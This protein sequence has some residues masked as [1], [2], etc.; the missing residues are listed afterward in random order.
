[1]LDPEKADVQATALLALVKLGRPSVDQTVK[2]LKGQ[3]ENLASFAARRVKEITNAK[4]PPKDKPHV[5]TAALILGTIGRP[6]AVQ[7]MI[8]A[9]KSTDDDINKA[10][11]ARELTKLPAT[12]A[13]KQAFKDAFADI[14]IDTVIPPGANA[15]QMLAEAAGQFYDPEFI[16]WLLDRAAGTKGGGEDLKSLQG[17]ITVTALKLA[18]PDQLGQVKAAVDKYGTQIE[19]DLYAHTQTVLKGCGDRVSCYLTAIEK[20]ENQEQKTQFAGIKAGYM[21]GILG[22]EQT[23]GELIDRLDA[24]DNAAVRFVAAQ[25]IDQLAPKGSK[26]S[27]EKLRKIIDKNAK[28]PDRDKAMADAPLKQVMY[29]LE[30][31]AG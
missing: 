5:R 11:I 1:M 21:I 8:E 2:L 30:A 10:V 25:A 26:D 7:P 19:K 13:S 29:R 28:S 16:P 9:I 4:E 22:N 20:S 31:R 15:L 14:S 23:R 17:V 6:E 3:N 12:P 24:I 18:K 27:A